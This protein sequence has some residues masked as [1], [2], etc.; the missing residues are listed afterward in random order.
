MQIHKY[1]KGLVFKIWNRLF[2][3][4]TSKAELSC[5]WIGNVNKSKSKFNLSVHISVK[6]SQSLKFHYF[7]LL[8]FKSRQCHR[9]C[10]GTAH[11]H[12]APNR[13]INRSL[14]LS[15]A[16][17][18]ITITIKTNKQTSNSWTEQEHI[19]QP[20]RKLGGSIMLTTITLKSI[21]ITLGIFLF[22]QGTTV[23]NLH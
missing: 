4:R 13:T 8:I 12:D 11:R 21:L 17:I 10:V 5:K 16:G 22:T 14:L 19:F 6:E 3:L 23:Y 7:F 1:K 15:V 2:S 18:G 20:S 9:T